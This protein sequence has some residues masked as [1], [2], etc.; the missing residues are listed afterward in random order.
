MR[1]HR[2]K[3]PATGEPWVLWDRGIRRL[4]RTQND[5]AK[6]TDT[7]VGYIWAPI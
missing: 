2:C 3:V 5:M 7:G 4:Y 6:N 1:C